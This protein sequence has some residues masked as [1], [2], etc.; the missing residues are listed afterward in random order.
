MV[1]DFQSVKELYIVQ[2]ANHRQRSRRIYALMVTFAV[3]LVRRSFDSLRSLRMTYWTVNRTTNHYW[4][5]IVFCL[6]S[7]PL[8]D[9]SGSQRNLPRAK[10]SVP[11]TLFCGFAA[12]LFDFRTAIKNPTPNG[13]GFFIGEL[14]S[15]GYECPVVIRCQFPLMSWSG[16][17]RSN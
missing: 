15:V 4:R 6:P 9:A 11:R 17:R 12:A 8:P 13:V 2:L 3:K 5:R 10:K 1:W 7:T 14:Q 16:Y